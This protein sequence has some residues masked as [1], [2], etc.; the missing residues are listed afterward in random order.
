MIQIWRWFQLNNVRILIQF[1]GRQITIPVNPEKLSIA[2]TASN[3]NID[4]LGIG[5]ATRK[6]EPGLP[7]TKISSFFPSKN[8]YF[9]KGVSPKTYIDFI[10]EIW[11]TENVNNNVAKIVTIGLDNNLNMYFVID[12]FNYDYN[13]GDD[14]VSFTLSIKQYIPYG[15]KLVQSQSTGMATARAT[16]TTSTEINAESE[17][18]TTPARTYTVVR[19]DCLWN[20]TKKYTGDGSRWKELYDL[21]K[22]VLGA[23]PNLI[24]PNQILTLPVGW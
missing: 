23:N 11:N 7:T 21:N 1:N 5:K 2:R 9:S 3:S 8:S 12:N 17:T 16:S 22:S 10:N 24:Y 19:G 6:G 18:P 20:I 14:D 13:A 15:V 4:I